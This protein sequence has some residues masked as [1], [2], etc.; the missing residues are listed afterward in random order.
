MIPG[1]FANT[2]PVWRHRWRSWWPG[3]PRGWTRAPVKHAV[4]GKKQNT[5]RVRTTTTKKA[6]K[7][8]KKTILVQEKFE[9]LID[10]SIDVVRTARRYVVFCEVHRGSKQGFCSKIRNTESQC[11]SNSLG[12][13]SCFTKRRERAEINT[14]ERR[15]PRWQPRN[16]HEQHTRGGGRFILQ[17]GKMNGK[18]EQKINK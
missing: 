1:F 14:D 8:N 7:Q 3:R 18:H 2:R 6:T 4:Q 13:L 9:H 5:I 12:L 10:R 11:I 15:Q 16:H 17:T